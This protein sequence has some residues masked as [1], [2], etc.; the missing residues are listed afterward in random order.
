MVV[1]CHYG[2]ARHR[3]R[4]GTLLRFR[5]RRLSRIFNFFTVFIDQGVAAKATV[6]YFL[7]RTKAQRRYLLTLYRSF[8]LLCV[9]MELQGVQEKN[10]KC[11]AL[12]HLFLK[13]S[14]MYFSSE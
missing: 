1:Y 14:M 9:E 11:V 13:S 5:I 10:S 7:I 8:I 2:H 6:V 12:S 4:V 3:T